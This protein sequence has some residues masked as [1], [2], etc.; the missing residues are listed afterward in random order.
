MEYTPVI[1]RSPLACLDG[2]TEEDILC[3]YCYR[4]GATPQDSE[5][6][7][8]R[9]QEA[10]RK[11]MLLITAALH[12][13]KMVISLDDTART[14]F[15]AASRV[16]G[17]IRNIVWVNPGITGE[18]AL[19]WLQNGAKPEKALQLGFEV[20]TRERSTRKGQV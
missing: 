2:S 8:A 9:A 12:T 14:Y 13:D 15:A 7:S 18:E 6:T 16:V 10:I 5:Q 1:L 17:E 4:S 19:A 3:Q 20:R 11:D